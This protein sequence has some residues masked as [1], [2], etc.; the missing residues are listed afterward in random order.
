MNA[1]IDGGAEQPD[2]LCHIPG[3]PDYDATVVEV[4]SAGRWQPAGVRKDLETLGK[5]V[6]AR[7]RWYHE[8][9]LLL[10]GNVDA[11]TDWSRNASSTPQR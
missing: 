5:L 3:L 2:L 10:F 6:T 9:L 7:D 11:H 4:K 1:V 8:G